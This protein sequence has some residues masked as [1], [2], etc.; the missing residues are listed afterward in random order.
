MQHE[1]EPTDGW[2]R[3]IDACK[4]G[5]LSVSLAQLGAEPVARVHGTADELFTSSFRV[6][7]IDIP[8][9]LQTASTRTCDDHARKRLGNRRS[10]VFAAP[11]RAVLDHTDY[12]EA[13]TCSQE[14]ANR[15]LSK[16]SFALVPKIAEVDRCLRG[17]TG[18]RENVF[19]VHPELSFAIWNHGQP[20]RYVKHS[21][22]GFLERLNLSQTRFPDAAQRIREE[23]PTKRV[24]DDDI[25]DALAAL[26]TA[27]RIAAGQAIR[28]DPEDHADATGLM[29]NIHA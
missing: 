16:Q 25:L 1:P 8:I 5:W 10:S 24:A 29:M 23:L 20:M 22:F 21:G 12:Q 27:E 15:G 6:T 19:E 11:V 14:V 13:N 7:A 17:G 3:G 26:W 28:M 9:G 4:G 2:I 18:L